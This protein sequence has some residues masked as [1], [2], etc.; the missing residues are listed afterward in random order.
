M[1]AEITEL[2]ERRTR[3]EWYGGQ[4][5]NTYSKLSFTP[6]YACLHYGS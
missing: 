6:E 1:P 5:N 3:A 4:F 2:Y